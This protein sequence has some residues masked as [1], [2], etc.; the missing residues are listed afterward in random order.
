MLYIVLALALGLLISTLCDKQAV[1]LIISAVMLLLP[2][3]MLSSMVF[4]VENM[5]GILQAVSCI[6]PAR[7]FIDAVRKLMIEGLPFVAVFK[8]FCILLGMTMFLIIVALRKFND[9]LE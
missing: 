7:W 6:I 5:P 4:P 8:N 3:I 1:A 9:K 2:V